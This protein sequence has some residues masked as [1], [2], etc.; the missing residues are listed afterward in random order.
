M[1]RIGHHTSLKLLKISLSGYFF[2]AG[3]PLKLSAILCHTAQ[4][5]KDGQKHYSVT[6]L[7][8]GDM[9]GCG[10]TAVGLPGL[11][12]PQEGRAAPGQPPHYLHRAAAAAPPLFAKEQLTS[13]K[14]LSN[15]CSEESPLQS[16]FVE[17]VDSLGVAS[18]PL[19]FTLTQQYHLEK[20][21]PATAA[22][23]HGW[24]GQSQILS[25]FLVL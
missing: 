9:K 7:Q 1:L 12:H 2:Q 20:G 8:R 14:Y 10:C 24:G 22:P 18:A 6:D 15:P 17:A 13:V 4:H 25:L 3:A 16:G 11:E 5:I 21:R 23:G 19:C